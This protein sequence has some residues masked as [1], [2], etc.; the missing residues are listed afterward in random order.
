MR[1]RRAWT[2]QAGGRESRNIGLQTSNHNK[3]GRCTALGVG[4]TIWE[5]EA[6][7]QA[8]KEAGRKAGMHASRQVSRQAGR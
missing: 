1:I 6:G 7:K 2:H 4:Q 5:N 3:T 8:G